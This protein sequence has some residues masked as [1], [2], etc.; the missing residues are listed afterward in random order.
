MKLQE[1]VSLAPYTTLKVGGPARFFCEVT[2]EEEILEAVRLAKEKKL[3]IFVLGGGSNVLVSDKGFEG[4]VIRLCNSQL[5]IRDLNIICDGGCQLSKVV[6]ESV[7]AGLAGLE[8]A[9]GI[10]GTVGGAVWGNAGAFG[11]EMADIVQFV[12]VL[13]IPNLSKI[14]TFFQGSTFPLSRLNRDNS[15]RSNL[16]TPKNFK[17]QISNFKNSDCEFDYKSSVFKQNPNLIILSA[18]LKLK[19]GDRAESEEKIKEILAKRREKQPLDF[20]SAGS[21]FKNPRLHQGFSGQSAAK[22]RELIEKFEKDT[23]EKARNNTIPAGYIIE[24]LGL[25]GK[26]IGGAMVSHKHANFLV[27]TG[28]AKAED[29]V[30]LAAIIKTRARNRFGIQ[31]KEEVQMIGF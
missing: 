19:K 29:F 20:P 9:A 27:N 13:E 2:R 8:W 11:G 12:K 25:K 30:I 26:K 28:N 7:K 4:V 23:G 16:E 3:P 17:F 5:A 1:N 22:S 14:Q 24:A 31:L 21:F 6:S 18:T 15:S 10:P